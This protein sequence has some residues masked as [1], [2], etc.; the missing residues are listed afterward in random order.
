MYD[1]LKYKTALDSCQERNFRYL[2]SNNAINNT[3][4]DV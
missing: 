4:I 2:I 3:T 1:C